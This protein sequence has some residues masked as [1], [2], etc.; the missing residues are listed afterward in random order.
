MVIKSKLNFWPALLFILI[1][2]VVG[3]FFL[4]K[5]VETGWATVNHSEFPSDKLS[6]FRTFKIDY[7]KKYVVTNNDMLESYSGQGGQA[8]PVLI[9]S[10]K[11][12]YELRE[13]YRLMLSGEE[14]VLI[15]ETR[16]FKN[17]D[18][19]RGSGIVV[20]PNIEVKDTKTEKIGN[21]EFTL[22]ILIDKDKNREIE[23]AIVLFENDISYYF[24]SCNRESS[25]DL[26]KMLQTFEIRKTYFQK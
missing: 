25:V 17:L 14:C 8:L 15:Q 18:D 4:S 21:Y 7:P 22:R 2:A 1:I 10:K 12:V 26:E 3:I 23:E 13:L 9:F 11:Q 16:G 19:W 20:A 24:Q 5:K 6:E